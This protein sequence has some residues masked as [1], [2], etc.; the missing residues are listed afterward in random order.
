M[1]DLTLYLGGTRSG[2]S[3]HAEQDALRTGGPVLYVA[4]AQLRQDDPA[5]AR[6][7]RAHQ[8]RRPAHWH[9]LEC[10]LELASGIAAFLR[11]LQAGEE[12]KP[13]IL[14]DCVTMWVTNILCSLPDPEDSRLLEEACRREV[15]DLLR[16]VEA[17]PC[18]WIAVSGETG[19][20]GIQATAMARSF[21]DGLGIANQMLASR[22]REAWFC[23]A[24]K[25]LLLSD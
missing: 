16:L 17:T 18:H 23:V 24:G 5:M 10:P 21:C 7:I 14:I 13:T 1:P 12:A 15:G 22:A 11:T 20:G 9:T 25:K 6:R 4:T 2:K 8:G 19:L 3:A